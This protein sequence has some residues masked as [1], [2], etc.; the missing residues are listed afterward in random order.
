MYVCMYVCTMYH[1][2]GDMIRIIPN[3][4]YCMRDASVD[5]DSTYI[6]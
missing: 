1:Y 3:Y 4:C 5:V 2:V 6:G